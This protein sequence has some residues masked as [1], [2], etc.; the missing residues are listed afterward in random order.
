MEKGIWILH[1]YYPKP[2]LYVH[3]AC[4]YQTFTWYLYWFQ[5][6]NPLNIK[7]LDWF[8]YMPLTL[9]IVSQGYEAINL[10]Q[11]QLIFNLTRL[12]GLSNFNWLDDIKEKQ[13][14]FNLYYR[15]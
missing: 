9:F 13:N 4:G 8:F 2:F 3:E 5:I 15:T 7:F 12:Y 6:P 11:V 10:L 1:N 14:I